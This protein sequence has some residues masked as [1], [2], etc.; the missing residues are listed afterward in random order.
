MKL[1]L[2]ILFA[3]CQLNSAVAQKQGNRPPKLFKPE[4]DKNCVYKFK[5]AIA[6][7]NQFYP[8]N[9]TNTI[10]LVSFRY[11]PGN[12]PIRKDTL[13]VDSLIEVKTLTQQEVNNLTNTLYNNFNKKNSNY[14]VITQCYIPH[15]AILFFNKTGK[16][17]AFVSICFH[18][19]NYRTSSDKVM[20]GNDCD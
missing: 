13:I 16:L 18:C 17:T 5:Y 11:H 4:S 1:L 3:I 9:I 12:Y 14:G 2:I 10:Q 19:G 15:N 7:R 6:Q 20:L 8:F